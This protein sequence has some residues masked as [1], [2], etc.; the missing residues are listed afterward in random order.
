MKVFS[1]QKSF[2]EQQIVN[3]LNL[4]LREGNTQYLSESINN[5]DLLTTDL[6]SDHF[7]KTSSIINNLQTFRIY[8]ENN[9]RAAGKLAGNEEALLMQNERETR[10]YIM[11]IFNYAK[12]GKDKDIVTAQKYNLIAQQ[13]LILFQDRTLQTQQTLIAGAKDTDVITEFNNQMSSLIN[14]L[15]SLKPLGVI[16]KSEQDD[17]DNFFNDELPN[18]ESA[19]DKIFE[20]ISNL[21]TLVKRYPKEVSNT[22][23]I[24]QTIEQTYQTIN[25]KIINISTEFV[26]VERDLTNDFNKILSSAST[27]MIII[28][29]LIV[30]SSIIIDTIQRGIVKRIQSFV[31]YLQRYAAGNFK[32]NID[33]ET[34]A[35]ELSS[36]ADSSNAL[37]NNL[38]ELI[39]DVKNRSQQVLNI[40][41]QVT[42]NS[43]LVVKQM[44]VQLEQTISISA[45]IEQMNVS[46]KDVADKAHNASATVN[47]I[48]VLANDNSITM[49]SA[50]IEIGELAQQVKTTSQ[51][52]NQLSRLATNIN[53]FVEVI[54]D[55]AEQTNLLALNAAI[56]AARAGENG[57]GFAVVADEV[58]SLSKRTSES[59]NEI[60]M[61]ID[62]I[63]TQADF[64]TNAMSKQ[65]DT[66]MN[67]VENNKQAYQATKLIVQATKTIKQMSE[68]IAE[69]AKQQVSVSDEISRRIHQ[70]KE[71]SE[72]TKEA[73]NLT[74]TLSDKMQNEN[75]ALQSSIAKFI[76]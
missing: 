42:D 45:S 74:S 31:P 7:S 14:E 49:E 46:F 71:T 41:Y 3:N 64:C 21:N 62:N 66:V 44:A 26:I 1:K 30:I 51:E 28:I 57:R 9:A 11:S 38:I 6:K 72:Q 33:I 20:I 43:S 67:T 47:D 53:S 35:E 13:L 58:R 12:E 55:I 24:K 37:R 50:S 48:S 27:L 36:L 52:I 32:Q 34:K 56:E 18:E 60:K 5:I 70:V 4:F 76:F 8:L 75:Q 16:E 19:E 59:T 65:V 10:D 73:A 15:K 22:S 54:N 17:L 68:Q 2:L 61:I 29:V 23:G 40:G 39:G 63:R 69:N 25:K